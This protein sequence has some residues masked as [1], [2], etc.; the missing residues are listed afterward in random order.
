MMVK[1]VLPEGLFARVEA[2]RGTVPLATRRAALVR[3]LVRVG[4]DVVEADARRLVARPKEMS[5]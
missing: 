3:E 1:L 2:L 4:L 5:R